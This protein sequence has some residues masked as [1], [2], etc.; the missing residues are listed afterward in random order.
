MCLVLLC[1]KVLTVKDL[2]GDA[3]LSGGY[4]RSCFCSEAIY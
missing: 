3:I 1:Y 2:D 4:E